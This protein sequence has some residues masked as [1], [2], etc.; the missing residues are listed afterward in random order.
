MLAARASKLHFHTSQVSADI[1]LKRL[2]TIIINT[3][4]AVV[5]VSLQIMNQTPTKYFTSQMHTFILKEYLVVEQD[6]VHVAFV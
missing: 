1:L 3:W 6:L 4:A 2:P 5:T